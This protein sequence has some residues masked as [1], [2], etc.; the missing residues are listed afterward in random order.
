[1][2]D[3]Q[4]ELLMKMLDEI[5][6]CVID[7]EEAALK[8]VEKIDNRAQQRKG[9]TVRSCET[10]FWSAYDGCQAFDCKWKKRTVSPVS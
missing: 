7:V 10:C 4:F 1:M 2:N 6:C 5:R 9:K 8:I 3:T